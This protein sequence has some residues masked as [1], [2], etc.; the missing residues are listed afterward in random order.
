MPV[1]RPLALLGLAALAATGLGSATAAGDVQSSLDAARGATSHLRSGIQADNAE[2]Q[3]DQPRL[4]DLQQRLT[5]L[6]SSLNVQEGQLSVVQGQLREARARAANLRVELARDRRLLATQLVAQYKSPQ[7]DMIGVIMRARGFAEL[8]ETGRSLAR[9]QRHN[10][11]ITRQVG[12]ERK[13]IVTQARHLV[14]LEAQQR[15]QTAAVLSERDQVAALHQ[16]VLEHQ[17]IFVRSR[18]SKQ[19]ALRRIGA[20]RASLERRLAR[21]QAQATGFSGA[22]PSITGGYEAHSGAYG[23]FPAPGTN[24][25]VGSEPSLAAHLDALGRALRL[26]L[27]GLSGY[28]SPQHSVEVG[29]FANDPHTRGGAS[30]TPGVEGVPEATLNRFGLTRPFGGAA[31][32]DHIQLSG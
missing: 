25:A 21:V 26:H 2:I 3:R 5:G 32:A 4:D 20:R 19:A 1:R 28:R 23:F 13:A 12:A 24:Y 10:V 18:A 15:A 30:D 17:S 22:V 16:S 14:S 8:L 31:E 9:I 11:K 27:I 29:G 6:Q 7:A